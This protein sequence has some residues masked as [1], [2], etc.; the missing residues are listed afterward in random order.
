ME[1]SKFG[2]DVAWSG[3]KGFLLGFGSRVLFDRYNQ[4]RML[5]HYQETGGIPEK[6]SVW[7]GLLVTGLFGSF[8]L[9]Y[10]APRVAFVFVILEILMFPLLL[11]LLFRP[12]VL[13]VAL[14]ATISR[15]KMIESLFESRPVRIQQ[16][17][18][19]TYRGYQQ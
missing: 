6:K 2:R 15:N 18:R 4:K 9:F 3:A 12:I 10:V 13:I 11:N 8:G 1:L 17:Y 19:Q 7:K 5:K 16:G 14:I